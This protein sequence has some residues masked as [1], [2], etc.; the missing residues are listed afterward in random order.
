MTAFPAAGEPT[1]FDRSVSL[2]VKDA[3]A[4]L[5]D[6]VRRLDQ[7]GIPV[8]KLSL[9]T[10]SLDQVFLQHTGERMRVEETN[11]KASSAM[12]SVF[13]RGRRR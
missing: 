9:A 2:P 7:A 5:S 1:T 6:L 11:A 4:S 13:R 8:A 3:G 12:H 10:P